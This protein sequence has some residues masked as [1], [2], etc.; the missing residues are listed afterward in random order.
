MSEA[1]ETLP[2][3]LSNPILQLTVTLDVFIAA[4]IQVSPACNKPEQ[5]SSCDHFQAQDPNSYI[6]DQVPV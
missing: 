5:Q 2:E 1:N 3:D 4:V 6:L